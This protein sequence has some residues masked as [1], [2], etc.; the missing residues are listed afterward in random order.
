MSIALTGT[1]CFGGESGAWGGGMAFFVPGDSG[2]VHARAYLLHHDQLGDLIA[3][4]AR[5]PVGSPWALAPS[6]PTRH[7]LSQVYDVVLDLG[8][9]DGH[10]LVTLTTTGHHP[11][12]PP[13]TGVRADGARRARRRVRPRRRG[14]RRLPRRPPVGWL[15]RWTAH[16]LRELATETVAGMTGAA[17]RCWGCA[18]MRSAYQWKEFFRVRSS[19]S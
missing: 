18:A 16:R 14:A 6:G 13:R 9:L 12:N 7:G 3:Q 1:L 8:R 4:E 11:P 15:P 17:Q 2:V 10:R 19:V 5:R